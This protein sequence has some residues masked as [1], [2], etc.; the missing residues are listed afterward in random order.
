MSDAHFNAAQVQKLKEIVNEGIQVKSEIQAL[1][2]GLKEAVD[3]IADE[4]SIKPAQLNKAISIAAKAELSKKRA[5][6]DEIETILES[7]GRNI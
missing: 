1:R 7:I 4:L 6:F 3:A 2:E 5:D